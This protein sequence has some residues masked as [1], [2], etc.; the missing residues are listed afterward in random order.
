MTEH[1]FEAFVYQL[2][3]ECRVKGE[4]KLADIETRARS[5]DF[6]P[7]AVI[8]ELAIEEGIEVDYNRGVVFCLSR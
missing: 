5:R 4:L 3:D 2:L 7:S 6:R 8:D 1:N